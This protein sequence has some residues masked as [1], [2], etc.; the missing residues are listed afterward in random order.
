MYLSRELQLQ[1]GQAILV[2]PEALV[3]EQQNLNRE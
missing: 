3:S 2:G 1:F